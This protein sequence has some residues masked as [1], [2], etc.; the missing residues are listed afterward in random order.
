[1]CELMPCLTSSPAFIVKHATF[2]RLWR[3]ENVFLQSKRSHSWHL[4]YPKTEISSWQRG[5]F[6]VLNERFAGSGRG[7]ELCSKIREF[8]QRACSLF[9]VWFCT[10]AECEF[11]IFNEDTHANLLTNHIIA[12]IFVKI[13]L[14]TFCWIPESWYLILHSNHFNLL[15]IKSRLGTNT[16]SPVAR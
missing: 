12:L 5:R 9:S 7:K 10:V 2:R 15:D 6:R 16:A 4:R 3:D 14:F 11:E 1:M 13:S 8:L